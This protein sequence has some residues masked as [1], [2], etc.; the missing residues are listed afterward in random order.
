MKHNN[1]IPNGH[2]RKY[3]QRYVRTWFNQPARKKSRR[4]ARV[5]RAAKLFPRPVEGVI[6]PVVRCQTNK[7]NRRI[8]IGRGFSL[9]ELK[10]AKINR[11]EARTI[12]I[13][14]DPRRRNKSE[15]S[16]RQNVARLEAYKANLVLFPKRSNAKKLRA[17]EAT[18][19]ER[20]KPVQVKGTV[21]PL[22][23]P[24]VTVQS[25]VITAAEK[26]AR[27]VPVLRK[28]QHDKKMWGIRKKRADAKAAA[29]ASS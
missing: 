26:E 11:N 22:V 1:V 27:V 4:E 8:R 24:K 19:E 5:A 17:G 21:L 20:S 9:D 29:A 28:A 13:S 10:A 16:I 2:F 14:V 25:R 6:R 23:A 3:W 12:G 7:Y 18:K 15:E